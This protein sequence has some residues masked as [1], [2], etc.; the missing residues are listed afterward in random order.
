MDE[1]DKKQ[2]NGIYEKIA[3]ELNISESVFESA[4]KSYQ[5]LGEYLSEKISDY[6]VEVFPQGSMNLGTLIKPVSSDDDYDLDVVCKIYHA[7]KCF[8]V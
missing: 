8:I 5:G 7:L 2:I 4:R 3:D 1:K 6:K